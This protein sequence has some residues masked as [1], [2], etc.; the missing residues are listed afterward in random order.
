MVS[1]EFSLDCLLQRGSSIRDCKGLS[2]HLVMYPESLACN[3]VSVSQG[4]RLLGLH[5]VGTKGTKSMSNIFFVWLAS[6]RGVCLSKGPQPLS[7]LYHLLP[8]C[9]LSVPH[10]LYHRWSG[11]WSK[12]SYFC[13]RHKVSQTPFFLLVAMGYLL[14][15]AVCGSDFL[16]HGAAPTLGMSLPFMTE[17]YSKSG[18]VP[19]GL[20]LESHI[21]LSHY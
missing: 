12:P 19:L 9:L 4:F 6:S 8:Y 14:S 3:L 10:S 11:L 20:S 15:L 17:T 5:Q 7:G 16:D 21:G 1:L 2:F 13:G 18:M